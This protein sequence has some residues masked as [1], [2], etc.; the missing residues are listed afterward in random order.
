M[1][2]HSA[3]IC[4]LSLLYFEIPWCK[5]QRFASI[6]IKSAPIFL[7]QAILSQTGLLIFRKLLKPPQLKYRAPWQILISPIT[8][9][10][11]F[12]C[13]QLKNIPR[14]AGPDKNEKQVYLLTRRRENI[15]FFILPSQ[16]NLDKKTK[17]M[18]FSKLSQK[19]FLENN[20]LG[21]RS[22]AAMTTLLL[23][24]QA[25]QKCISKPILLI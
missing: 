8:S 20:F 13:N 23:A 2:N 10:A 24:G 14:K 7:I 12:D 17:L 5:M 15:L 16:Q 18:Q 3:K 4:I 11:T 9:V 1:D 25:D 19:W 21:L 6:Y 22:T